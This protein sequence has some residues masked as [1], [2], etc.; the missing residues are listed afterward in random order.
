MISPNTLN[1]NQLSALLIASWYNMTR[2]GH[3]LLEYGADPNVCDPQVGYTPLHNAILGYHIDRVDETCDFIDSLLEHGANPKAMDN[4]GE[5]APHLC[6]NTLEFRI[7]SKFLEHLGAKEMQSI[8]DESGNTLF[9]YAVGC[10]DE[11]AIYH[12]MSTDGV[13]YFS[14]SWLLNILATSI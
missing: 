13:G 10:L 9:H 1:K 7:M 5:T 14:R 3:V 6:I 12:M 4:S 11:D 8:R 2:L